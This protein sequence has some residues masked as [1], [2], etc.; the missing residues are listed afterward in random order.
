MKGRIWDTIGFAHDIRVPPI[1]GFIPKG[2]EVIGFMMTGS[3]YRF[4]HGLRSREAEPSS[5]VRTNIVWY[6]LPSKDGR[7]KGGIVG[8][9]SDI[10]APCEGG[11]GDTAGRLNT[12]QGCGPNQRTPHWQELDGV[13]LPSCGHA[14]NMYCKANNCSE[15]Q[16]GYGNK[17]TQSDEE[18][19]ELDSYQEKVCC[20]IPDDDNNNTSPPTTDLEEELKRLEELHTLLHERMDSNE[21]IKKRLDAMAELL[22]LLGIEVFG[23]PE[24]SSPSHQKILGECGTL[25]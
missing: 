6:R 10:G 14:K 17:C 1:Q 2:G 23:E 24:S 13:C 20:L 15:F 12:E 11:I 22:E 5:E 25:Y 21:D 18:I 7:I 4:Y 19:I 3:S 8:C 16:S 9:H